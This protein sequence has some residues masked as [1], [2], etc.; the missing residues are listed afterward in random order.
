MPN[1]LLYI[2]GGGW[3]CRKELQI[4]CLSKI[5]IMPSSTLPLKKG[6]LLQ[7]LIAKKTV[8]FINF[9]EFFMITNSTMF[10]FSFRCQ[11]HHRSIEILWWSRWGTKQL[12]SWPE[13]GK[14]Q[15]RDLRVKDLTRY[16]VFGSKYCLK[17]LNC[18]CTNYCYLFQYYKNCV[19]I[20]FQIP[21][22]ESNSQLVISDNEGV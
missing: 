21:I 13:Q 5:G 22:T 1:N 4:L 16:L 12:Q 7:K 8:R 20:Q 14:C 19:S 2:F 17:Y 18:L 15:E 11:A 3:T 9:R 10:I 6:G